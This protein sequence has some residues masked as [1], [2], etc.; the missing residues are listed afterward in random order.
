MFKVIAW[1][2]PSAAWM[3]PGLA[4]AS[5]KTVRAVCNCGQV[6]SKVGIVHRYC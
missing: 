5:E 6:G 1:M 2:E 4:R 3:A